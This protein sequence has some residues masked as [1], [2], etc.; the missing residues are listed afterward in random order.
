MPEGE[1]EQRFL[2]PEPSGPEPDLAPKPTEERPPPQ[3][4]QG[5][6]PPV[7]HAQPQG[8]WQQ[9]PQ[10]SWQ[11][12]PP[13]PGWAGQ[14]PWENPPAPPAQQ[15]WAW[16]P[17]QPAVPD[18]GSAVAGFVL[19]LT[20]GGLL[21]ISVGMSSVISIVCAGLGIFYSRRGRQRVERG[22]T[23]K[24]GGLARAGHIIGIVSLVLAILATIG[25]I[26]VVTDDNFWDELER[27]LEESDDDGTETSLGMTALRAGALI[28][29]GAATLL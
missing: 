3:Y 28:L 27:E 25:W 18:N 5:Y 16:Q 12:H 13:P 21:V 24:H 11:Q 15:P 7:G 10:Q 22:E 19:S 14:A 1:G 29:R 26:L 6:A 17:Q 9:P 4:G 2:P 23:P 20:A 8:G